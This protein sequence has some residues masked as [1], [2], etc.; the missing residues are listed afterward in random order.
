M[1]NLDKAKLMYLA[2]SLLVILSSYIYS[3]MVAALIMSGIFVFFMAFVY[4]V[5]N[6][7]EGDRND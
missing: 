7:I 5:V 4:T 6:E 3:G 1:T 2:G